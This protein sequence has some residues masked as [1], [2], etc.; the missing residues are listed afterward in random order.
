M[1][2][3]WSKPHVTLAIHAIM[4]GW[5]SSSYF[6][7]ILLISGYVLKVNFEGHSMF[8]HGLEVPSCFLNLPQPPL[9]PFPALLNT[10]PAGRRRYH[11]NPSSYNLTILILIVLQSSSS[12]KIIPSSVFSASQY[13]SSRRSSG[14]HL[15][16]C[17]IPHCKYIT[18]QSR[19]QKYPINSHKT[20]KSDRDGDQYLSMKTEKDNSFDYSTSQEMDP[21][22]MIKSQTI[23]NSKAFCIRMVPL[24][25]L[26]HKI[27]PDRRSDLVGG[28]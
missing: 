10:F 6:L 8:T 11:P 23:R 16:I 7:Q 1:L 17:F 20:M 5:V 25:R 12:Q 28:G 22:Q 9:P 13:H 18:M 27:S 19:C 3:Y 26:R 14:Y 2:F 24:P 15:Q 4:G 21:K